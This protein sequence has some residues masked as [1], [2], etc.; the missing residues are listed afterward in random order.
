MSDIM[1]DLDKVRELLNDT[2]FL[3]SK[4]LSNEVNIR[5]FCY[6][7]KYEMAVRHFVGQVLTGQTLPCHLVEKNLYKVFLAACEERRIL[8]RMEDMEKKK[9][10]DAL[11]AQIQ[12]AITVQ[13]YV[14]QICAEPFHVGDVL[15]LTGVGDAFPFMRVHMVLEALQPKVNIPI[16]VMYPGNFDGRQVSLFSLLKPNPYYRAFSVI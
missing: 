14:N 13:S 5:V 4:G 9:G 10:K 11:H 3:E 12:K 16:L 7:P 15:L 6:D 8:N 1:A 2:D